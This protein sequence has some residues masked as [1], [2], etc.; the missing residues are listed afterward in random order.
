MV[1]KKRNT[2]IPKIDEQNNLVAEEKSQRPRFGMEKT[3]TWADEVVEVLGILESKGINIYDENRRGGMYLKGKKTSEVSVANI[4][5]DSKD[6][7][8]TQKEETIDNPENLKNLFN[9]FKTQK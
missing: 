2:S 8:K 5:T 3:K 4:F 9:H 6:K 7:K 1:I